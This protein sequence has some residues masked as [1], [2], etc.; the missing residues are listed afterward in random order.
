MLIYFAFILSVSPIDT[1]DLFQKRNLVKGA[2]V[3]NH[4]ILKC[5]N[6]ILKKIPNKTEEQQLFKHSGLSRK[7]NC[8]PASPHSLIWPFSRIGLQLTIFIVD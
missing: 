7:N 8:M 6:M 2:A 5:N 4:N 3:E 1:K